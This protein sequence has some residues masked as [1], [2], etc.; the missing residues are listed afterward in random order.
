M[1]AAEKATPSA[2]I[3]RGSVVRVMRPESYWFQ[4]CGNVA[5]V[6]KG[7]ERYGVVVRFDKVNYAGVATNNFAMDE[8]VVVSNPA[9]KAKAKP[10]SKATPAPA[11]APT[12]KAAN[13]KMDNVSKFSLVNLFATG[14]QYNIDQ[15][16]AISINV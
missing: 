14:H 2:D 6:S 9:A 4:E 5:T 1:A 15:T 11:Q 16:G 12:T 10:V 8:L 7:E 3:G 13:S